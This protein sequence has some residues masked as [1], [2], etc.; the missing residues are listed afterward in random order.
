MVADTIELRPQAG[1]QDDFAAT[2]ADICIFGGSAGPGKRLDINTP[3]AT[4]SGWSLMGQ[5]RVGDFVFDETGRPVQVTAAHPIAVAHDCY[6]VTFD[7]GS[8]IDADAD[9]LWQ[10]LTAAD[11]SA[12]GRRTDAARAKR[13]SK[14]SK[15]GKRRP[16]LSH[17]KKRL[18]TGTIKT[19]LEI[20]ETLTTK[21]GRTNHTI[22]VAGALRLPEAVLPI[23][24]YLLGIWLGDGT[25]RE[26][27]I[28]T[29]DP[30]VVDEIRRRGSVV[31]KW[32]SSKYTHGVAGLTTQIRA[33]GLANN[34]HIPATY[35]RAS[36]G[37]RSDLFCGLMD[38]DGHATI[39]GGCEFTGTSRRLVYDARELAL[40]LG[41]KPGPI[42]EGIA[43]LNRK[44]IGRK[45]RFTMTPHEPV[46]ILER[47]RS[48]Q[49]TN[50]RGT[51]RRRYIR[52]VDK[53]SP[54]LMRCIEVDSP[55][56]LFLAGHEL[57]P[58]HNSWS[59]VYDPLRWV[60]LKRFTGI[61]F[62]RLRPQLVGGGSVWEESEA[63]Y[64]LAGGRGRRGNVLDWRF[65]SGA[66]V[67]FQHC[68]HEADKYSHKSKQYCYIGLD[69]CTDFTEGQFWYLNSRNRSRCG[70]RPYMRGATNPDPDSHIR[71]LIAWWIGDPECEDC[72]TGECGLEAH[73]YPNLDR[74]GVLRWFVRIDDVLHWANTPGEL[75][76]QFSHLPPDDV[77][78]RSFTFIPALLE[79][80]KILTSEDPTYRATLLS[81]H[82]V[83]KKQLLL[84]NWNA[85]AKAGDF[86]PTTAIRI[87]DAAPANL[88]EVVRGW[89][90]AAT[91]P[92]AANPNPDWT[93]GVKMGRVANGLIY[94]LDVVRGQWGPL[95]VET[96]MINAASRD[97]KGV[98]VAIWQD[99]A[100]AGKF[101]AVHMVRVLI[102]YVVEIERASKNKTAF[103]KPFSSQWLAGNVV[104]VR[105]PWNTPYLR[106]M[107]AF[108]SA[109][110]QVKDDDVDATSVA[111]LKIAEPLSGLAALE[112]LTK[113]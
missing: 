67:E 85:R 74:A 31:N 55:G 95:D 90:K 9:H 59:L 97:G 25:S 113:M 35:M 39:D 26:G 56:R 24:P 32:P 14:R 17:G 88:I 23:D 69:E 107:E 61:I 112:A 41:Y 80:N 94:I 20:A 68:Q 47:K 83:D 2:G 63:M 30:G 86:F 72:Q 101:D 34:K 87:V 70:V 10:T 57:I 46:F 52:S 105:A 106:T 93:V 44:V 42:G 84:G 8:S 100:A 28:T 4:P 38:S 21:R 5:L 102:G 111:Y 73:G 64:P 109:D 77:L 19:T 81:L 60:Y 62:R 58:T 110:T 33:H 53:Q 45:F 37:Q 15:S 7:D 29:A 1:P 43:T 48:R 3:I 75:K 104:L 50:P 49:N 6:R 36:T 99:P 92:S 82:S 27:A 12:M 71:K 18:P 96:Q 11:L 51:T 13:R 108:P 89:D 16:D 103:A 91:K 22:P 40:T 98:K 78:P 66:R 54:R 76:E 79:H 65:P